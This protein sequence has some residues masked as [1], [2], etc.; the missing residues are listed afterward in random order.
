MEENLLRIGNWSSDSGRCFVIAEVGSN[1]G[2]SLER[3]RE[4]IRAAAATGADA[5][6][7][8]SI[9]FDRIHVPEREPEEMHKLFA[10]I[11]LPESW[12]FELAAE[13]AAQGIMFFS[14][15]T[16]IEAI[17]ILEEVHVPAYKLA[18][19]QIAGFLP[20]IRK[21]A[22]TGKPLILS[23][24]YVGLER[25]QE[26]IDVCKSAGN[27][28]LAL[29]HCVSE[30]PT[31]PKHANLLGIETMRKTF[32]YPVGYSD[33][34]L[35]IHLAVC[36]VAMGAKLIEKHFTLDRKNSGPDQEVALEP[37]EFAE[38]V[39][40]IREAEQA[41]GNGDRSAPSTRDCE[42]AR[43]LTVRCLTTRALPAGTVLRAEHLCFRRVPEGIAGDAIQE[44]LGKRTLRDLAPL[45]PLEWDMV[46]QPEEI[47]S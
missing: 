38:M 19:P 11:D 15:P 16:Y 4:H 25:V 39:R 35:G 23:S 27:N 43:K 41:R 13:A 31:T 12:H 9:R 24:G 5:V 46:A 18:S 17:D 3:A 32:P 14:A 47:A 34:T 7:F 40:Q 28:R 6:K 10:Q 22:A 8:Q 26:A 2:G 1:H 42:M 33:H 44:V 21:A 29:L 20:L 37:R 45:T 30:Y 36:A